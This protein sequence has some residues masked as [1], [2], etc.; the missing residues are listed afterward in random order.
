MGID[1]KIDIDFFLEGGLK[2]S[3]QSFN[4]LTHPP[5]AFVVFLAVADKDIVIITFNNAWHLRLIYF[6]IKIKP[7]PGYMQNFLLID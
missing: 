1:I 7:L 2:F 3:F 6:I 5:V 4:K